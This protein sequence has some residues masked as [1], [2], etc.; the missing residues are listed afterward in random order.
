MTELWAESAAATVDRL[1]RGEVSPLELLDALR[2]RIEAVDPAVNALPTRCFERAAER[3]RRLLRLPPEARGT[4][5]GLP[6]PIKDSMEVEGVRT[7]WGSPIFADHVSGHSDWCVER[8]ESEGALVYAKSNT[9][10]FEA[11]ANTFNEVF[12]ATLNPWNTARSAAGSSGGAAVA[13]ATGMAWMAQGSDLAC[14]LRYPA[15]FCGIVGLRPS[16]GL[17]ASGPSTLP[18]DTLAVAGPLARSVEDVGLA[19]D[20]MTGLEPRDPLSFA[21]G[22]QSYRAA[23]RQSRRPERVAASV[24]LGLTPVSAPVRAV[25]AA[26]LGKL[27]AAGLAI[28]ETA[29]DLGGAHEAFRVLRA[30]LFATGSAGLLER[31]RDKLKPELVWNIEDGLRLDVATIGAAERSRG[32]LALRMAEFLAEHRFLLTP[33]AIVPPYPVE[34][35]WVAECEGQRFENY[36]QWMSLGYAVTLTACPALSLP[37]GLTEDGLPVGL[38]IV[39][40]PRGEAALLSFAH[41][42]ES[43]LGASLI[44]PIDPRPGR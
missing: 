23:A 2:Q 30:V 42:A 33:T 34:Q 7:T 5:G 10:E 25:F 27:A 12:G 6:F 40:P 37:C 22:A 21:A 44:R 19:L 39:G 13:V 26:A 14:S 36:L 38:Q 16:P 15:S 9:P 31:H 29:P 18:F 41:W 17:V 43:V 35:R 24:D 20:A 28:E 1:H 4:L 32:V 11:G 8:L 3:A